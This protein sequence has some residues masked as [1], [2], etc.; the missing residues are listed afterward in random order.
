MLYF[1]LFFLVSES[2][3]I[4][5]IC[6]RIRVLHSDKHIFTAPIIFQYIIIANCVIQKVKLQQLFQSAILCRN[7]PFGSSCSVHQL[8]YKEDFA[9]S[10]NYGIMMSV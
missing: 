1:Y 2:K 7:P 4:N 6:F 8:V 10:N 9:Y 3:Q 5:L